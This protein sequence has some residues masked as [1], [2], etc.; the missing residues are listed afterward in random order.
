MS[1]KNEY[2]PSWWN[3]TTFE[4]SLAEKVDFSGTERSSGFC[5]TSKEISDIIVTVVDGTSLLGRKTI[6]GQVVPEDMAKEASSTIF[7]FYFLM[8]KQQWSSYF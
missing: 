7:Y 1:F 6:V 4:A 8:C 3:W 2:E 5:G